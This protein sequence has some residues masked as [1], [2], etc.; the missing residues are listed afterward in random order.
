[1]EVKKTSLEWNQ[2]EKYSHLVI[3]D[4]DGWDRQN[5]EFSFHEELIT[6]EEFNIRVLHSTVISNKSKSELDEEIE[7]ELNRLAN[8]K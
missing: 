1:M 8:E 6:E 5:Y 3:Y 7:D 2:S 4:P